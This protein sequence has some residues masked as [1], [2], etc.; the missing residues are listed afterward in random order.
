[1]VRFV[2][3]QIALIIKADVLIF[4]GK[5]PQSTQLKRVLVPKIRKRVVLYIRYN[6]ETNI[7]IP[8]TS[9]A[10]SFAY[11]YVFLCYQEYFLTYYLRIFNSTL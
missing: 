2:V 10:C 5:V 4:G 7:H 6:T 11:V 9:Y 8:L 3:H 1:M